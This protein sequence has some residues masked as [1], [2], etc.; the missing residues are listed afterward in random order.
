MLP[1]GDHG[2]GGA[3]L[4]PLHHRLR[5]AHSVQGIQNHLVNLASIGMD[6]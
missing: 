3:A 2:G 1:D 6:S 4:V 5:V